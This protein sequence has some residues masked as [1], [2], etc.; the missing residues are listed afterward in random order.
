[1]QGSRLTRRPVKK[2]S[3]ELSASDGEE[4]VV[5]EEEDQDQDNE[6]AADK[7]DVSMPDVDEVPELNGEDFIQVPADESMDIPKS[8][9]EDEAPP[10]AKRGR[11]RPKKGKT[12]EA[13]AGK[14]KIANGLPRKRGRPRK[15]ETATTDA[16]PAKRV[17][18]TATRP[19][20]PDADARDADVPEASTRNGIS[21]PEQNSMKPPPAK[22]GPNAR[23]K[24]LKGMADNQI[25]WAGTDRTKPR[26]RGLRILRSETPAEDLGATVMRSG[27][28]SVKPMAYWRNER[29]IYGTGRVGS[30]ERELGGIKEVIRT[31]EITPDRQPRRHRRGGRRPRIPEAIEDDEDVEEWET[32]P[33][34]LEAT[35]PRW[36][37]RTGKT[38]EEEEEEIGTEKPPRIAR[39][40][41]LTL[42]QSSPTRPRG[43]NSR[44]AKSRAR[45]SS[46][47]RRS[48]C[49][50]STRASW[51]C[52]RA[53]RSARRTRA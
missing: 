19:V 52:H 16:R 46:T 4:E 37:P 23:S 11:G 45:L 2:R 3:F 26:A 39:H 48:V 22:R 53:A 38:S 17:K 6:E 33:G 13:G 47:A 27:R 31:E 24:P 40:E 50:S 41:I 9:T 10:V 43:W 32:E 29:M 49:P 15:H 28:T 14:G 44:H 1:M 25:T 42:F 7:S 20:T 12:Q 51:I 8:D 35:V 5:V 36:D 34:F 18:K 30:A 21:T